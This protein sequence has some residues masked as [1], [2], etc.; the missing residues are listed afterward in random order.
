MTR[1]TS[2]ALLLLV[3]ALVL[4]Q[5]T[6]PAGHPHGGQGMQPGQGQGAVDCQGMMSMHKQVHQ[7]MEAMDAEVARLAADMNQATGQ[8]KV[9]AMARVINAMVEQR[10]AMR[11]MM[12]EMQPAMM[13]H[14]GAHM[15]KGAESMASCP[16]MKESSKD[17][18]G[19]AGKPME[20][21][22]QH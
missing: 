7:R 14:M 17:A 18:A 16:M 5:S 1:T 3:P 2:F 4:A 12:E 21:P 8:A 6:P 10:T 19:G 13:R 22:H 15:Q 11:S 9:D 20:R